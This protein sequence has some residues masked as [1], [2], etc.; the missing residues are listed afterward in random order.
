MLNGIDPGHKHAT[1]GLHRTRSPQ[2]TLEAVLPHKKQFGITR[3]ANVTGLDRIGIPVALVT[4]PN[5]KSVAVSQGKGASLE[6]AKVSAVMEAIELWHAENMHRPMVFASSQQVH[7]FGAAID[8][9]RLPSVVYSR[10]SE[11]RRFHWV[12]GFDVASSTR[13]YIPNELVHAEYAYPA[14]PGEGCFPASTNGLAS[15]NHPLEAICHGI[16]EV[17]E[18]DAL[19]VWYHLP[20][21]G[22][23]ATRLDIS[24]VD[25]DLCLELVSHIEHAGLLVAVWD[26][27]SDVGIATFLCL[28]ADQSNPDSHIGLGSGTHSAREVALTRALSEAA[29]TRMN[30]IT[31]SRDDLQFA[32]FTAQGRAKLRT[33]ATALLRGEVGMRAFGSVPSCPKPTFREDLDWVLA[34]LASIGVNDVACVDLSQGLADISV[35]RIVIPGLEAPHDDDGFVAGPRALAA[36][37]G[38]T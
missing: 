27:T 28:I 37:R 36:M 33:A 35:F 2:D 13:I 10:F 4:R 9:T 3:I 25:D 21:V 14:L 16:Y 30:Y 8:V 17:I 7:H 15:G 18:R 26:V 32:E 20:A 11:T 12:E 29:Q 34:R 24:S 1:K 22:R 31:G 23:E 6:A 38:I 5:S 19:T